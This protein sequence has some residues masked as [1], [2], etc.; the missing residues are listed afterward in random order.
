MK[1]F[2]NDFKRY[3]TAALCLL[4]LLA[5]SGCVMI[6]PNETWYCYDEQEQPLEGVII[7]CHYGLANSPKRGVGYGISDALGKVTFVADQDMPRG[8][9]RGYESIYSG[10]LQSG[11]AGIGARWHKGAPIP[12]K[13]VY[14]DE[15]SKCIY[16]KNGIG[17]PTVWNYAI[18]NLMESY[19]NVGGG[20]MAMYGPGAGKLWMMLSTVG[21]IER[22]LFLKKHG[23]QVVPRAYLMSKM[24][25]AY[26]PRAYKQ[27]D[28]GLKFKDI[29]LP[30]P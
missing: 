23:D 20:K 1:V 11:D 7:V 3:L 12:E 21:P 10:K 26:F 4:G 9:E 27:I 28:D 25:N 17:N 30:L 14:F 5:S 16:I 13:S 15:Y 29:T 8:L 22:E 18:N 6:T 2:F 24:A 19:A